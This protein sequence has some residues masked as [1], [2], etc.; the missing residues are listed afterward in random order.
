MLR[1]LMLIF[2]TGGV[3][4]AAVEPRRAAPLPLSEAANTGFAD[5]EARDRRGGWIDNGAVQDLRSFR[6][7]RLTHELADFEIIDPA[8]N[9]GRSCVVLG[10]A[11]RKYLPRKAAQP[12]DGVVM[13]T[14]VLL[15]ASA[16]TPPERTEI[17]S[18]W[19]DFTDNTS[20]RIPVVAG[21][22]VGN[23][24][25]PAHYTNAH[26]G[27]KESRDDT[28][29][30][31][32]VSCFPVTDKPVARLRFESNGRAVWMIVAAAS[33][34]DRLV[35]DADLQYTFRR[36]ADWREIRFDHA[37]EPGSAL[38]FSFQLDAPAGKHGFLRAVGEN[39]EFEKRPGVP[40]RFY[41]ANL[42]LTA[43]Y[44]SHA[45]ADQLAERLSRIGYN[46]IRLHHYDRDLVVKTAGN[47]LEIDP[48]QLDRLEYLI[49]ALKKRGLYILIDLYSIRDPVAGEFSTLPGVGR[50]PVGRRDYKLG[51]M[52][53]P[54][55]NG[56]LKMFARKL[57][58][59][60]NPYTGLALIDEPA[61]AGVCVLNEN[62][63]FSLYNACRGDRE[64]A[65]FFR[66]KFG[67]FCA[68]NPAEARTASRPAVFR[69][70]L[71]QVYLEYW[72]DM[73][74]YLRQLGLR[75]PLTELNHRQAPLALGLRENFDYVDDHIYWDHPRY[76][77]RKRGQPP[78]RLINTSVLN[79]S[80]R[81]LPVRSIAPT[82]IIGKPF[83]VTE[84]NFCYP[85]AFRAEGAPVFA[86]Y[87][88]FQN[89][90]ALYRFDYASGYVSLFS[91]VPNQ[92]YFGVS[93]DP[94][95]LLGERIAAAFFVRGD[96]A[97][98]RRT[99][100]VTVKRADFDAAYTEDFP[101]ACGLAGLLERIGSEPGG[102]TG[103]SRPVDFPGDKT[104]TSATGE[105]TADLR[106]GTFRAA[107]RRS[108]ALVLP[109]GARLTGRRLTVD[110]RHGWC[111]AALI[112]RPEPGRR[113]ILHLTDARSEGMEFATP[114]DQVVLALPK[115][116]ALLG[117]RGVAEFSVAVPEGRYELFALDITGRR[118]AP[119]PFDW[120]DGRLVFTADTFAV[121]GRVVF[122]YE[123]AAQAPDSGTAATVN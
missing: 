83:T 36:N 73:A 69:R 20:L 74:T 119:V 43:N 33:S 106:R 109:E 5:E 121:P 61:L 62:M 77:N 60:V 115:A 102:K 38:D 39:F 3:L 100:P 59:H 27:W 90:S 118:L 116:T 28:E 14:L 17:G 1:F 104:F 120:K 85:N 92:S 108:E 51:A 8:A 23:W 22:D 21:Q 25:P 103:L 114:E 76:L 52:L 49:A 44:M 53:H 93:A 37:V 26:V 4:T 24:M 58:T 42:T 55:M 105:I 15:H 94:V 88:A 79:D 13:K 111:V 18:V 97:A 45:E 70:F 40:V 84:Y 16:W 2:L 123:L 19:V 101:A 56:N 10:G 7:G 54:E 113:L 9:Q 57:L 41:G 64:I 29:V 82:R 95:R 78:I 11:S 107:G 67:E 65:A 46:A 34:P 96:L 12:L 86:A 80:V 91:R 99:V 87:A 112:D 48:E 75:A 32:Y 47:S 31:L 110:N 71:Y 72:R 122:A 63:I 50:G 30:G 89:W 66:Q 6:P 98:G 35:L 117:R 68:A 81:I